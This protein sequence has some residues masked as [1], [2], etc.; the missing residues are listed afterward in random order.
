MADAPRAI[1]RPR[2]V[3]KVRPSPSNYLRRIRLGSILYIISNT[4]RGAQGVYLFPH[5]SH[6]FPSASLCCKR[7]GRRH[8]VAVAVTFLVK[9]LETDSKT[10][11]RGA[12]SIYRF[13]RYILRNPSSS[14]WCR[15]C[16]RGATILKGTSVLLSSYKHLA[17]SSKEV[18]EPEHPL[19]S[20]ECS[21]LYFLI[22][23]L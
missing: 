5:L 8:Q 1:P 6:S 12:L 4:N 20:L 3:E 10:T 15:R 14:V 23:A 16:R 13:C 11:S 22:I 17:I 18:E 7:C 9:Q 19:L 21:K 2:C